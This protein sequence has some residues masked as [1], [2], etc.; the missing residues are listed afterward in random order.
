ML[1][2]TYAPGSRIKSW[3]WSFF[4][5]MSCS[6]NSA[7]CK[8]LVVIYISKKNVKKK[9]NK[10][11]R[12]PTSGA[13]LSFS[14][15]MPSLSALAILSLTATHTLLWLQLLLFSTVLLLVFKNIVKGGGVLSDIKDLFVLEP[16]L[17]PCI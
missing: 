16:E 13:C 5:Y 9:T 8:Q 14:S 2:Q 7:I 15:G 1:C 10:T 12:S 11:T 3:S 6:N 4:V 17:A